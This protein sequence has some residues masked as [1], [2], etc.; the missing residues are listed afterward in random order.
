MTNKR[1]KHTR[2]L[3]AKLNVSYQAAHNLRRRGHQG[4]A[5][6][7]LDEQEKRLLDAT[8]I[9]SEGLKRNLV[10]EI[11]EA[12]VNCIP[13]GLYAPEEPPPHYFRNHRLLVDV[14]RASGNAHVDLEVRVGERRPQ[15]S[16]F[17][18]WVWIK[19]G[20][21]PCL[22]RRVDLLVDAEVQA[23]VRAATRVV[24]ARIPNATPLVPGQQLGDGIDTWWFQ[25]RSDREVVL[26]E[27]SD[28]RPI[29]LTGPTI[30]VLDESH[31]HP[32]E[33]IL[34]V[35]QL[36]E[37]SVRCRVYDGPL[38]LEDHE[39]RL[40]EMMGRGVE[41]YLRSQLRHR[42][43][44]VDLGVRKGNTIRVRAYFPLDE[45]EADQLPAA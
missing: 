16:Q 36:G 37:R 34:G 24:A 9:I 13:G 40:A 43:V 20:Q 27:V 32:V 26:I 17:R 4:V 28:L 22:D 44:R 38:L 18:C 30:T 8:S 21:H 39:V 25:L 7:T 1:K 45:A 12:R 5:P 15:T 3:E 23:F 2:A 29:D 19:G 11:D 42:C 35:I 31:S 41:G 33:M 10:E 14:R 6:P